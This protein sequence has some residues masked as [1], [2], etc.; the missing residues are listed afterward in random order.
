MDTANR[1]GISP[2]DTVIVQLVADGFKMLQ[3]AEET[4]LTKKAVQSRI[5]RLKKK[6][7]CKTITHLAITLLREK[8][9][10]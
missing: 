3:V 8:V 7:G 9:I 5:L 1:N 10:K 6:L 4:G 2:I